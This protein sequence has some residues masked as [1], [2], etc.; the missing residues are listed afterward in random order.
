MT[1]QA[2]LE[3][4]QE[5]GLEYFEEVDRNRSNVRLYSIISDNQKILIEHFFNNPKKCYE[6]YFSQ[7][8]DFTYRDV[9]I[10]VCD[11]HL[12]QLSDQNEYSCMIDIF[13]DARQLKKMTLQQI[14]KFIRSWVQSSTKQNIL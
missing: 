1:S 10:D 8:I 5:L 3:S 12:L 13:V 7:K 11:Y 2:L 4:I 14:V 9:L 6:C